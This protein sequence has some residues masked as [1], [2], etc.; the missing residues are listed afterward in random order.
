[1]SAFELESPDGCDEST[2][3]RHK[4]IKFIPDGVLYWTR[5]HFASL[6]S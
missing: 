4:G 5:D 3:V 6:F 2:I 1:M